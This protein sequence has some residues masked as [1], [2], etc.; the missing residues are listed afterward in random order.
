MK[1][2]II[3]TA[4]VTGGTTIAHVRNCIE[5][6]NY[7]KGKGYYCEFIDVKTDNL[8]INV[9]YDII[10][11]SAATFYFNFTMLEQLLKNQNNCR[12]GWM[13]NEFE[14]FANGFTK[15]H[16]TFMINNFNESGIKKAHRHDQLLTTNLNSLL[17]KPRNPKIPKKYDL[18]YWGTYRKYRISYF[19]K[20]FDERMLLSTSIKNIKKFQ[21][22]GVSCHVTDKLS[23]EYQEESLNF[24]KAS[25]YIEDTK[26]HNCFNYMAN[27]FFESLFCN[28]AMFF[29][30]SCMNTIDKDVFY[31]DPYFIVNDADE[32]N[33]RV[34]NLDEE[35]VE[36]FLAVNTEIALREKNKTLSEIEQFL[37]SLT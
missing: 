19:Q 37:L 10:L 35:K 27:R 30:V 4:S 34:Q 6:T 17:A 9:Q 13:T 7:L 22:I 32:L 1:I 26:T 14:L 25:I 18:C 2:L 8:D 29:D 20:Y 12:V 23:W 31:I 33:E 36:E 3:E 15:E 16:M 21:D 28:T 5:I 24:V 11:F